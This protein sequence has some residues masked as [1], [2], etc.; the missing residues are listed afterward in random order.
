M[1]YT[2]LKDG[3]IEGTWRKKDEVISG[4]E[5]SMRYLK[6]AGQVEEKKAAPAP[7]TPAGEEPAPGAGEQASGDTPG[8]RG[9]RR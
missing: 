1:N 2:V 3:F 8:G 4:T 6:L 9:K 5:R 7:E